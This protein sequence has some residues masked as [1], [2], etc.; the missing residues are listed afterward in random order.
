MYRQLTAHSMLDDQSTK[1]RNPLKKA[2]K[3]RGK[4]V[5]FTAPTYVEASDVEYSTEEEGEE[6]EVEYL[7]N[8]DDRSEQQE[9]EQEPR[10]DDDAVVEPLKHG[11]RV[12][13]T[14]E[15]QAQ[16][17]Q[18]ATATDQTSDVDRVRTSDEMFEYTGT[19]SSGIRSCTACADGPR[20]WYR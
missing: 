13:S 19:F 20:R 17:K 14:S 12:D 6:G 18:V 16:V 4:T 3:R 10:A 5:Q 15:P 1:T 7:P 8:E 2:M 11:S 9:P